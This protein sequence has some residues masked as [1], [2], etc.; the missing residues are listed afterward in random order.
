MRY[1][2][3]IYNN[4]KENALLSLNTETEKSQLERWPTGRLYAVPLLLQD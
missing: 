4:S 2:L 3:S 1:F